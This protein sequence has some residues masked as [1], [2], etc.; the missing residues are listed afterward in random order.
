MRFSRSCDFALRVL[1]RLAMSPN[2]GA[3]MPILAANLDI[4]YN[5]LT[6][7]VQ[8]L[9]HAKIIQTRQGKNG[10]IH[11]GLDPAS[12]TLW[13][14]VEVMDGP[15]RL[16]NCF[17]PTEQCRLEPHCTIKNVLHKVQ[18]QMD[19]VLSNVTLAHMI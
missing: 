8:K 10:G 9:S 16:A 3:T 13:Q 11:L 2:G 1:V 15:S 7:I 6:K 5:H 14:I 19:A 12:L 4:S 18:G 17:G